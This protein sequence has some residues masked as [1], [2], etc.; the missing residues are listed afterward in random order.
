M[1]TPAGSG[2]AGLTGQRR[3]YSISGWRPTQCGLMSAVMQDHA[4]NVGW[5]GGRAG[6]RWTARTQL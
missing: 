1:Q 4:Y 5:G 3:S 2:T 6:L